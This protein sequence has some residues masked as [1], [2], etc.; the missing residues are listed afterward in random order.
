MAGRRAAHR[1]A[2]ATLG[3]LR[4]TRCNRNHAPG[5]RTVAGAPATLTPMPQKCARAAEDQRHEPKEQSNRHACEH[6]GGGKDA[7][8]GLYLP[9]LP[10]YLNLPRMIGDKNRRGNQPCDDE[11]AENAADH[12]RVLAFCGAP[13]P[14]AGAAPGAV[15]GL[16]RRSV[17]NS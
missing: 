8:R 6:R 16:P 17:S 12:D 3:L 13:G 10:H 11:K 1:P 9:A 14:L 15:A 5:Q 7:E 4:I 2:S